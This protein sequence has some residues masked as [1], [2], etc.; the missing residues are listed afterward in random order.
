[1]IELKKHELEQVDG[2]LVPLVYFA[3]G[4]LY[5]YAIAKHA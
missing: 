3:A 5:G 4:A 1:M 2:G